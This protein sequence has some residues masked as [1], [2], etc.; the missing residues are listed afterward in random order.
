LASAIDAEPR[1]RS[2]KSLLPF[3][4]ILR[5]M[6]E[7]LDWTDQLDNAVLVQQPDVMNAI[8]RL[9]YQ[10]AAARDALV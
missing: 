8:Q 6:D 2:V 7:Q 5:M 1:D 10:A 4:Q 9:R 3:P